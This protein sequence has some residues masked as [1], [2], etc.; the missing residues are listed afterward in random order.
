MKGNFL[1]S[2]EVKNTGWL[3]GEQVFQMVLSFVIS[4]LSARYLGPSN[5]GTLSYT[6]SF[7]TFFVAKNTLV[8]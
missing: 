1:K 7:V 5:Y 2:K 6:L 8:E 3:I 4:I